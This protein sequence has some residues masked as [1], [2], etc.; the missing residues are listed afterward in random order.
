MSPSLVPPST[1]SFKLGGRKN[2]SVGEHYIGPAISAAA[3]G[4]QR[5]L[6]TVSQVA[7][8]LR[9]ISSRYFADFTRQFTAWG[10]R[11][12]SDRKSGF[13]CWLFRLIS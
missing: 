2:G 10:R 9:R 7:V 12:H 8:A 13:G 11:Q 1:R 4:K 5:K 6:D 3:R